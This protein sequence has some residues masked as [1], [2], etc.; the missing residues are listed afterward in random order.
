MTR[1]TKVEINCETGE[2]VIVELTDNEIAY[3]E[4]ANV[5]LEA[6]RTAQQAEAEAK[7]QAKVS[8][9]AKLAALGLTEE[10]AASIAG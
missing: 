7:A 8:A 9:L 4:E 3:L 2:E 1:P 5:Q 6:E 10:E